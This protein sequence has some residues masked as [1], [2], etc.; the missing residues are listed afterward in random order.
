M[1]TRREFVMASGMMTAACFGWLGGCGKNKPLTSQSVITPDRWRT[2]MAAI[3]KQSAGRLGVAVINTQDKSVYGHSMNERF[4]MCS[5]FK[6]LAAAATLMRVDAGKEQL[7][8]RIPIV[9]QDI[10]SYAPVTKNHL[11]PQGMS[12]AELCDAAITLSDN[13]AA[14]LLLR[15]LGGPPGITA[16]ARA[17]G[18]TQ[19]RLDRI[20]PHL[21]E[22]IPDDPRDTTTP[23]AMARNIQKLILGNAL[24]PSSRELLTSWL[25]NNKTGNARLRAGLPADW[26]IGDKTG[27]GDHGTAN[28]VGILWPPQRKPL[29]ACVYLTQSTQ[30]RDN[31]ESAIAS[32]ARLVAG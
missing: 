8:R 17:L 18:D 1:F 29:I 4:A 14:N 28:D 23:L 9:R 5:T 2:Q 21:N 25:V 13:T 12:V 7:D 3:E 24:S 15:G 31:Q 32:V 27:T 6:L 10:L 26:R 22:A 16:C 30:S 11:G 20:E 19:T